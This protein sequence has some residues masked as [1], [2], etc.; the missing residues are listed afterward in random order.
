MWAITLQ[1]CLFQAVCHRLSGFNKEHALAVRSL[2]IRR[3]QIR[4]TGWLEAVA[5][6]RLQFLLQ[7][8]TRYVIQIFKHF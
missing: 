3:S 8:K 6:Y 2:V 5:L 1:A 4:E 7:Q